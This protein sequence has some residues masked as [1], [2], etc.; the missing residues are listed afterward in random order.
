MANSPNGTETSKQVIKKIPNPTGKGGFQERP[1]D[2]NPGH[3]KPENTISYQ[4]NRFMNMSPDELVE[5]SETPNSERTVAMDLAYGRVLVAHKSLPDIKEIT[6]RTEGK[7]PQAIDLTSNGETI[8]G[9]DATRAE[10]LLRARRNR[11][12]I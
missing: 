2:R 4:Y 6:D 1:Q 3:W 12:D 9:I 10:E 11:T 7:A 8:G 5:W